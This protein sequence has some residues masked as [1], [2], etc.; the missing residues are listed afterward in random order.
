MIE[1]ITLDV[2]S[3]TYGRAHQYIHVKEY[4]PHQPGGEA[5]EKSCKWWPPLFRIYLQLD[6]VGSGWPAVLNCPLRIKDSSSH[7]DFLFFFFNAFPF[8][9]GFLLCMSRLA[10]MRLLFYI[11][12]SLKTSH[13]HI[14]WELR[15]LLSPWYLRA[16]PISIDGNWENTANRKY[17]WVPFD[18]KL[19]LYTH[20]WRTSW[21]KTKRPTMPR[22]GNLVYLFV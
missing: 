11:F 16:S 10:E 22:S 13:L 4:F 5:D 20:Y 18:A 14:L 15:G 17:S 2:S 8:R 6:D 3:R 21:L 12:H 7:E 19:G 9:R 1:R